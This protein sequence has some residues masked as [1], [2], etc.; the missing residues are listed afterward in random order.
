MNRGVLSHFDLGDDAVDREDDDCDCED[1][2]VAAR[3]PSR[4][5]RSSSC[6]VECEG[7][8][9]VTG[10]TRAHVVAEA[11]IVSCA[12]ELGLRLEL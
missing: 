1:S 5:P 12:M 11:I 7:A 3:S 4:V 8:L 9:C 10:S 6:D 2:S